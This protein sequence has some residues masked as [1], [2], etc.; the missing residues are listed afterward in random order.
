MTI[1]ELEKKLNTQLPEDYKNFISP[2]D[3]QA[4]EFYFKIDNWNFLPP[5]EIITLT[6][7]LREEGHIGKEDVAFA[8]NYDDSERTEKDEPCALLF[9]KIGN[10]LSNIIFHLGLRRD[11]IFFAFSIGE[12]ERRAVL[13]LLL[14]GI[15]DVG[16][17][18]QDLTVIKDCPGSLFWYA[19][20]L[21]LTAYENETTVKRFDKALELFFETAEK[22]HPLSA[23]AIASHYEFDEE[24]TDVEKVLFWLEKSTLYG[25]HDYMYELAEFIINHKLSDI[26]KAT[27]LLEQLLNTYW[28]K[29]RA[30]LKLSRIHMR[31]IGG[32]QDYE[33]GIKYA[34]ISAETNNYN[35]FADLGFYY[36]NGTGVKQDIKKAYEL[37]VK[38][39]DLSK[40]E[41]HEEGLWESVVEKLR[42]EIGKN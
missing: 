39:N 8:L 25:S 9:R 18:N 41:P 13:E 11:Q 35:A 2:Y 23:N 7:Q 38:A 21:K 14:E 16:F 6:L 30:A 31:N 26:D 37:M 19:H 15:D 24:E 22:G 34:Q 27:N 4:F 5:E 12:F 28:Y 3:N 1:T 20:K 33:K 29:D 40:D 17:E 42:Q 10:K 36:Y 32:K